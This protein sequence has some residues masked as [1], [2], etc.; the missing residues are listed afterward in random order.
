[1]Q[2]IRVIEMPTENKLALN[3]SD[4]L[5]QALD[6]YC[7]WSDVNAL[8][9]TTE[10]GDINHHALAQAVRTLSTQ[11]LIEVGRP[12]RLK[13]RKAVRLTSDGALRARY[14][15]SHAK[16]HSGVSK[17]SHA[18]APFV[19]G[20]V[21]TGCSTPKMS[22]PF[23][24]PDT[25][26]SYKQANTDNIRN[27][28]PRAMTVPAEGIAQLA[29]RPPGIFPAM[30]EV[31]VK[32]AVAP[33]VTAVATPTLNAA[34]LS[35]D[36]RRQAIFFPSNS[37]KIGNQMR[38]LKGTDVNGK[39]PLRVRLLASTDS[40]GSVEGNKRLAKARALAVA[41]ELMKMGIERKHIQIKLVP[42]GTAGLGELSEGQFVPTSTDAIARR[43]E[44][45]FVAKP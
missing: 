35:S 33:V 14:L 29:S 42:M 1:M 7:Q 22:M 37:I 34:K 17:A 27:I 21:L 6:P 26:G 10:V 4:A 45:E 5:V 19:L 31:E 16:S 9:D 3:A 43:V 13:G 36:I 2:S 30:P 15:A 12:A 28:L 20:A 24:K 40:T 41:G 18:L 8:I 32:P 39:K 44:V 11:R 23:Q 38:V 25:A